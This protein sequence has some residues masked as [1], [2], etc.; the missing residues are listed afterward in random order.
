LQRPEPSFPYTQQSKTNIKMCGGDASPVLTPSILLCLPRWVRCRGIRSRL[1]Q[2]VGADA[3]GTTASASSAALSKTIPKV[4]L[5]GLYVPRRGG[6]GCLLVLTFD[7]FVERLRCF[8]GAGLDALAGS[9]GGLL[10]L[11]REV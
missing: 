1:P 5:F 3:T 2:R 4:F 7:E 6:R 11:R 9:Q 10:S 8:Q